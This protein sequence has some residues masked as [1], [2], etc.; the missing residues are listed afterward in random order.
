VSAPA[1]Y[2]DLYREFVAMIAAAFERA[3]DWPEGHDPM[4]AGFLAFSLMN[5]TIR[6][7]LLVL[8]VLPERRAWTRSIQEGVKAAVASHLR[9]TD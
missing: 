6:D 3:E 9:P 4:S 7:A 5:S 8:D 2:Q 1:V